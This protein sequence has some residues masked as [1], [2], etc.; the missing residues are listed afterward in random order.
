MNV[1][2]TGTPREPDKIMSQLKITRF[3]ELQEN[4]EWKANV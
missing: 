3:N 2:P 1:D 4:L